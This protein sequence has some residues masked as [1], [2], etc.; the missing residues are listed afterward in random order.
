[1]LLDIHNN[2]NESGMA[3]SMLKLLSE[4]VLKQDDTLRGHRH[5]LQRQIITLIVPSI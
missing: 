4:I 2:N 1:M 3:K 5:P